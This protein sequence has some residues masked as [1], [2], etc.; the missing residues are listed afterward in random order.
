MEHLFANLT[1]A[2]ALAVSL[3]ACSFGLEK[4]NSTNA[5]G[6]TVAKKATRHSSTSATREQSWAAAISLAADYPLVTPNYGDARRAFAIT[7]LR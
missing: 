5:N 4:G 7:L 6:S 2:L 1:L 3:A